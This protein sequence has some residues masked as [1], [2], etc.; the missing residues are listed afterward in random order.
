ML[1]WVIWRPRVEIW[2]RIYLR[3]FCSRRQTSI[4][5]AHLLGQHAGRRHGR[6]SC[7]EKWTRGSFRRTGNLLLIPGPGHDAGLLQQ[8]C[9]ETVCCKSCNGASGSW[10]KMILITASFTHGYFKCFAVVFGLLF[11][12]KIFPIEIAKIECI[13]KTPTRIHF[14]TLFSL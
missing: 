11:S 3:E 4:G 9:G 2:S 8:D 7:R 1:T 10:I 6:R 12:V 5:L 13:E 14:L